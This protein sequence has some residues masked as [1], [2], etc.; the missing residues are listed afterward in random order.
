MQEKNFMH[1]AN[2]INEV[3]TDSWKLLCPLFTHLYNMLGPFYIKR[4]RTVF[5][6]PVGVSDKETY[7][8]VSLSR[9]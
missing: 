3:H 9:F 2:V 1:T 7:V 6:C 4:Q 5:A 8:L